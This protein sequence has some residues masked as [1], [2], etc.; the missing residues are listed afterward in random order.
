MTLTPL[1]D[2]SGSYRDGMFFYPDGGVDF[3]GFT[4]QIAMLARVTGGPVSARL[5]GVVA[6]QGPHVESFPESA[7]AIAGGRMFGFARKPVRCGGVDAATT[8]VMGTG[9]L[10]AVT[11]CRRHKTSRS[12]CRTSARQGLH[13]HPVEPPRG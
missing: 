7:S 12:W 11:E 5:S 9:A 3:D 6:W 10:N 13:R 8:S 1:K 4:K 2:G